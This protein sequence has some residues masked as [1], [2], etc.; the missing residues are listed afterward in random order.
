MK[1]KTS[2]LIIGLI[3]VVGLAI[4]LVSKIIFT[5]VL[6]DGRIISVIPRLL[7]FVYV[8]NNGAAFGMLGGNT[9]LLIIVTI[10]FVVGFIIYD[11]YNHSNNLWY[12][13]G[14]GLIIS[15]AIGNFIDRIFLGYVRDFIDLKLFTF[16][17]NF[18]DMF[19]TFGVV[20]LAIYFIIEV[21]KEYKSKKGDDAHDSKDK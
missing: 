4:D 1:K 2:Y 14:M 10:I 7:E 13:I 3:I 6:S 11:K 5:S 16:V 20:C 15:G 19:I 8:K 17:F 21:V 12:I 18:A 9:W